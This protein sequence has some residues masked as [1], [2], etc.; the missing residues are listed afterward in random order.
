MAVEP[1]RE[2][3]LA[4]KSRGQLELAS[5]KPVRDSVEI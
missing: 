4:R 1:A 3:N 5:Q 2:R